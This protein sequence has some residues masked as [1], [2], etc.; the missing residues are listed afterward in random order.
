MCVCACVCVC[1]FS[2]GE[3]GVPDQ[4]WEVDR[5]GQNVPS[6]TSGRNENNCLFITIALLRLGPFFIINYSVG[7]H[8]TDPGFSSH[9]GH[10]QQYKPGSTGNECKHSTLFSFIPSAFSMSV[11]LSV[12]LSVCLSVCL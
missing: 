2:C 11:C 9:P 3:L 1:V 5:T 4:R 12:S 6:K 8:R 7:Y 10:I